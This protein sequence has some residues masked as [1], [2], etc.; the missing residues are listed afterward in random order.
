M[1]EGKNLRRPALLYII[2]ILFDGSMNESNRCVTYLLLIHGGHRVDGQGVEGIV[3]ADSEHLPGIHEEAS[4]GA[5]RK[6]GKEGRREEGKEGRKY[7][8]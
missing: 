7:D 6:E 1:S 8:K 4:Q 5:W 3:R 2:L